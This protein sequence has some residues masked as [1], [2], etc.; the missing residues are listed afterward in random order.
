[1]IGPS[2]ACIHDKTEA[3]QPWAHHGKEGSLEKTIILGN[4]EGGRKRRKLNRRW[5]D[6]IKEATGMS[7]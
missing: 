2:I 1:M 6:F 7:L 5:I 4:I 3:I